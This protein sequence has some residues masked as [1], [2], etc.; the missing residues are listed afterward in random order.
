MLSYSH[1][2]GNL[3]E[4]TA[5]RRTERGGEMK[6]PNACELLVR[7]AVK[8]ERF[9]LLLILKECKTLEEFQQK[10]EALAER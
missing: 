1:S 6:T 3:A 9:R 10:L 8:A 2:K 7:E 4:R 5:E